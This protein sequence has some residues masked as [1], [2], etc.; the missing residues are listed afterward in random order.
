V[1]EVWQGL[2]GTIGGVVVLTVAAL[3]VAGVVVWGLARRRRARGI[4]DAWWRSVAEVGIAYG[5]IPWVWMI[6]LPNG[7]DAGRPAQVNLVPLRDLAMVLAGGPATVVVQIGGN[8]LVF[9]ALGFFGPIRFAAL[10]SVPRVLL[11]G[12]VCSALV[13]TAQ[14]MFHLNRV[15]SVDDVLINATGA[16]LAALAARRWWQ[17]SPSARPRAVTSP[18][19]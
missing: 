8:L 5:T 11:L 12:A 6:L 13:E 1:D 2:F 16:A 19:R 18:R 14:Y 9:A 4:V 3:P 15:S 7:G 10:R 17:T